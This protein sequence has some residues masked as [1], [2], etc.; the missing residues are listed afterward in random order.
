MTNRNETLIH[1]MA[2]LLIAALSTAIFMVFTDSRPGLRALDASLK[3]RVSYNY[4]LKTAGDPGQ[5]STQTISPGETGYENGAANI[6]TAI[7][8]DYRAIDTLGEVLV[9]FA[10]SAGVGLLMQKRKRKIE[11]T[12]SGIVTTAVPMIML[13]AVVTGLYIILHGHL[14]PGGGFPGGAVIASAYMI[15]FLAFN[16]KFSGSIFK[17]L[18]SLAGLGILAMG[19]AGLY[20][21]GSFLANFLPV[22]ELG[23]VFSA[24][25]IMILYALIG[26]KVASELSSIIGHFI[27]EK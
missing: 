23:A 2:F 14:T 3:E 15:Q 25:G 11:R 7:V 5:S 1:I 18:E 22:G 19:V 24:A 6:V 13:F 4:L 12:A 9:L 27:G 17:I 16:R 10:A 21:K 8:V 20:L 26:I